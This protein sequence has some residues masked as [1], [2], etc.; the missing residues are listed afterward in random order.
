MTVPIPNDYRIVEEV[1]YPVWRKVFGND[2]TINRCVHTYENFH[3]PNVTKYT[4]IPQ[5]MQ[6]RIVTMCDEILAKTEPEEYA[7]AQE[8]SRL[9]KE[10][11]DR[12][13]EEQFAEMERGRP[14]R[15]A[16]DALERAEREARYAQDRADRA[17]RGEELN[18]YDV[19]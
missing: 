6:T 16:R 11:R 8:F 1:I 19:D 9:E 12:A 10:A 2:R 4:I 17:A 14:E 3:A 7:A 18:L 5:D 15:E 13:I